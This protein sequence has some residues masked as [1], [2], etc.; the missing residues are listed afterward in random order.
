M[1]V[2]LKLGMMKKYF[3]KTEKIIAEYILK[4]PD[5]VKSLTAYE[6][7]QICHTSQP[8]IIRFAKKL[9]FSG[10]PAFKLALS[11]DMGERS[12]KEI[13]VIDREISPSDSFA[14]VC[15]K[16]TR[17]NIKAIEDTQ[18]LLD[19]ES[20]EKAIQAISKAKRIMIVGA[21]FSGVVAKD[22]SYKLLELGKDVLFESDLHIQFSLLTTMKKRDVLFV[23]SYSGR[24]REV[25][26]LTKKAK[27][28]GIQII[29]LTSIAQNPIRDL[30]DIALN[31]IELGENYRSTALAPR[32]S[33][34]TIIDMIYVKLIL[35]NKEMEEKIL[36]A[37]EIVK[38]FKI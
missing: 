29:T 24:T 21:G 34:M 10:Y 1:S 3:S 6:M 33:Q 28:R 23:V 18:S 27:E 4:H 37:I 31:T 38:N 7:G 20:L 15:Q 32:I 35:E 2:I 11:Q 26:E 19:I 16:I 22:F 25:Y 5:E 12:A 14:E 30:S 17:E 8:S 9:G 13:N 36:D